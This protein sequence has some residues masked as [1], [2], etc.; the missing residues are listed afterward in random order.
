MDQETASNL[1]AWVET[2]AIKSRSE[3][4]AVFIREGLKVRHSELE[5]LRDSLQQVQEAKARLHREVRE[6]FGLDDKQA[7]SAG[8]S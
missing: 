8:E 4:A 5:G 2:G 6:V 1:D 3:T 7:P